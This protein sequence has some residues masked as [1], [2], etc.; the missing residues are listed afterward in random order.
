MSSERADP[1]GRFHRQRKRPS[2]FSLSM[3]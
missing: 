3:K 2:W 1:R